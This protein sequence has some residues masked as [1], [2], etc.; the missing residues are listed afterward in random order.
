MLLI[1]AVF[2]AGLIVQAKL[3]NV[4]K[5]Y[6]RVSSPGALT[7]AQ[8]AE[9]MLR[10]NGIYDVSVISTPGR[11][12]DHYNPK[13]K[14]INLSQSVYSER[15]VSAAAVA[16]HETGHAIQD[17]ESYAPLRLRSALVPVVNISSMF[18]QIVIIIGILLME[19]FPLMFWVGIAMFFIVF[20]FS[21][22]T[23]PVEYNASSRA[24]EW[25]E[26]S[27]TMTP[28]EA[29]TA[30]IPLKWAARTY[31][32]AALSALA[33]LLYYLGFSSRR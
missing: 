21:V 28:E 6:S 5:K 30:A 11:L 22:I 13:D 29:K 25:L 31:L 26:R 9:K 4:F 12:T 20:L 17:A 27:G 15:S 16:A 24:L 18:A 1:I 7:G 14:T 32:V 33:T 10:D 19:A 23:L 8:I 3:D 2:I